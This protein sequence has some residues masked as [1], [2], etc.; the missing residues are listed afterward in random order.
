LLLAV[1]SPARADLR[2]QLIGEWNRTYGTTLRFTADGKCLVAHSYTLLDKPAARCTWS[3]EGDRL[4]MTN[5]E[6]LCSD[7]PEERSGTYAITIKE[8]AIHFRVLKDRCP[9]RLTID[10]QTWSRVDR[11]RPPAAAPAAMDNLKLLAGTWHCVTKDAGD[12]RDNGLLSTLVITPEYDGWWQTL[13]DEFPTHDAR[14][15]PGVPTSGY[16]ATWGFDAEKQEIVVLG[17]EPLGAWFQLFAR[18]WQ[19]DHI[20]FNGEMHSGLNTRPMRWTIRRAINE[21]VQTFETE[22]DGAW[23]TQAVER[24]QP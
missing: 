19:G 10:G 15:A 24:C 14:E 7:K 12:P 17:R 5:S 11:T 21:I 4:T 2:A 16:H 23:G 18:S 20:V 9:R 8:P 1:A 13:R 3:L 6:G 22:V